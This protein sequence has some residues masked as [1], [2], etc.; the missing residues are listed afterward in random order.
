LID[1][2]YLGVV[3]KTTPGAGALAT[4]RSQTADRGFSR[5]ITQVTL[6]KKR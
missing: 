3:L 4:R 1:Y 6:N 5:Q 2:E